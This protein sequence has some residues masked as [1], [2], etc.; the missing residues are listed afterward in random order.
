ME[1][2]ELQMVDAGDCV[3]ST[4]VF[5]KLISNIINALSQ[6]MFFLNQ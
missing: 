6:T 4:K 5:L 3:E 2:Y 1:C